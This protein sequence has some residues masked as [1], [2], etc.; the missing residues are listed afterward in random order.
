MLKDLKYF[1]LVMLCVFIMLFCRPGGTRNYWTDICDER[2]THLFPFQIASRPGAHN[3]RCLFRVTF[4]PTDA[5]ELLR[6]DSVAFEYLYVQCCNDVV[7]ERFAPELKYEVALR[8]AALHIH[9]HAV[10]N[11]LNSGNK[12]RLET[13]SSRER[14]SS[15]TLTF[16]SFFSLAA[17]TSRQKNLNKN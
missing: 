3:L 9:Q 15:I 8:L 2:L 1:T 12:V 17:R 4:V 13:L 14:F 5:Y 6:T 7:Q 11:G 16:R 10:S